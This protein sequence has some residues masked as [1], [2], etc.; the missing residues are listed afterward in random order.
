MTSW[1]AKLFN[2]LV[3]RRIRSYSWGED[4]TAVARRARRLFGSPP[5]YRWLRSM[6]LGVRQVNE[7][8]IR[9][10]WIIPKNA[11]GGAILYLH[12]GGFV[13]CSP[14]TH[15]PV[16]ADVARMA[17]RRVFSVDYRLAPEHRFPAALDDVVLAYKYLLG[18]GYD[19]IAV[20]GDSAGG[21]LVLSLM[22][23]LRDEGA[24]MPRAGICLSAWTDLTGS[25]ASIEGNN[26][27]CHM[28]RPSN[29]REFAA[30]YLGEH[31]DASDPLASP[32]NADLSG[33][34]P[35]LLQVGSTEL[36]LDDSVRVRE[37]IKEADGECE[38]DV[39]DDLA[40]GWYMMAGLVPEAT[41]A[42]RRAAEFI[43]ARLDA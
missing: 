22:V 28:F 6:G 32:L 33:L 1:Q 41:I 7:E 36:L 40:H 4:E 23:R 18:Q 9:G 5:A 37:R 39:L 29:M 25:G 12:G 13:S 31:A 21:G 30:A 10:E 20:A 35:V 34:P 17:G 27:K 14:A 26:G 11:G 24:P 43:R 19:R 3:R 42:L 8:N 38:L 16:T 15:R 2:E